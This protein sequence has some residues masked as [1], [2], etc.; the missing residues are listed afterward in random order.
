MER[1]KQIIRLTN[2][3]LEI[4]RE[5]ISQT[6]SEDL[7]KAGLVD[8]W[9]FKDHMAHLAHWL[10]RLNHRLIKRDKNYKEITDIDRENA[11]IWELYHASEW[12]VIHSKLG[13]AYADIIQHLRLLSEEDLCAKDI[14]YPPEDRPLWNSILGD[15]CTHTI[16]HAGQIYNEKGKYQ[17]SVEILD[18]VLDDLQSLDPTP[19][20]RGTNIYNLACLH[21]LAGNHGKALELMRESFTLRPDLIEWSQKDPDLVTLREHQGFNDL[22]NVK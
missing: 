2:Y 22:I 16:T 5:L 13:K 20:W 6:S 3:S 9:S 15:T 17:K 1:K 4:I 10:D 21:S 11:R 7:E 18:K 12:N 14:L 19:R 8:R